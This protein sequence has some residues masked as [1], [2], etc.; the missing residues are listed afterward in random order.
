MN[1]EYREWT[2]EGKL[3]WEIIEMTT[4]KKI[5]VKNYWPNGNV[6]MTGKS[7]MP[8]SLSIHQWSQTRDGYWTYRHEDNQVSK[9]EKYKSGQLLNVE[10][11]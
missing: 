6:K 11:P 3:L 5:E 8:E 9:S 7:L 2:K 10:M 1:G 4:E